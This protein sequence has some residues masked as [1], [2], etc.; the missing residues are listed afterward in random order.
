M[1]E[2]AP[3]AVKEG[4]DKAEADALKATLEEA[5]MSIELK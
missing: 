5:G 1:V 4:L 2:S 3:I